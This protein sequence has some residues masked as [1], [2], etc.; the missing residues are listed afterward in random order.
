M[1]ALAERLRRRLAQRRAHVREYFQNSV[2]VANVRRFEGQ[3]KGELKYV[4]RAAAGEGFGEA[5]G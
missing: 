3:L 5:V 2:G 1:R 4:T